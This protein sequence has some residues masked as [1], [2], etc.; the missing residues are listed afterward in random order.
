MFAHNYT[1]MINQ[2]MVSS[3]HTTVKQLDVELIG[4]LI[5]D[6]QIKYGGKFLIYTMEEEIEGVFDKKP[7]VV[8]RRRIKEQRLACKIVGPPDRVIYQLGISNDVEAMGFG[9]RLIST[10]VKGITDSLMQTETEHQFIGK[11]LSCSPC[12]AAPGH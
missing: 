12:P 1:D 10:R 8:G 4:P 6:F 3:A 2:S 11:L 7:I 5:C 9:T